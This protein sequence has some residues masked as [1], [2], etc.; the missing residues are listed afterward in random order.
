MQSKTMNVG[1]IGC[2]GAAEFAHLPAFRFLPHIQVAAIADSNPVRLQQMADRFRIDRRFTNYQEILSDPAIEAVAV[3]V[4]VQFH[5]EVAI[6]AL[7]AGKHL[8]I[9]K[10][11]ALTLEQA[12]RL[13]A[14]ARG[15]DRKIMLGFNLRWHRLA[16]RAR[17][18]LKNGTLGPL[19]FVRSAQTSVHESI[20]EWRKQRTTGGGV[21]FEQAVHHFDLWRFLIGSEVDEV[22]AA[23]RSGAWEDETAT[24]TARMSNGLLAEGTFAVHT[25]NKNEVEIHGRN[26]SLSFSFYRFDSLT[27]AMGNRRS[28]SITGRLH[29]ATRKLQEL[30]QGLLGLRR[31]GDFLAS[32]QTEWQH[33]FDAV[34]QDIPVESTLEDGRQALRV[35]LAAIKSAASGRPV[36][37]GTS[38]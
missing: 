12:D 11:L 5:E 23:S 37:V 31:G 2:G 34:R 29:D 14:R 26:G 28:Q 13:A 8:F 1:L 22:F 19:E 25:S 24:I 6:A 38:E 21:F 9:E 36:K 15:S 33:F 18:S 16:Q 3:C 7:D 27:F 17:A 30:P 4:P 20:P 32:Y 10:P 35:V